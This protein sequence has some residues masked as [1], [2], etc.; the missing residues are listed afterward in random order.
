MTSVDNFALPYPDDVLTM[1]QPLAAL[2]WSM[3]LDSAGRDR[4]D[5]FVAAPRVTLVTCGVTTRICRGAD[6]SYSTD[7]PLLLLQ[8]I[9]QETEPCQY[10]P[11]FA[12]GAVGYFAYDLARRFVSL[13]EHAEDDLKLPEM[14]VGIYD[15]AVVVDHQ[16]R[17]CWLSGDREALQQWQNLTEQNCETGMFT[18]QG[19]VCSNLSAQ[20]YADRFARVQHYLQVG[21]CYQVNLAQRFCAPAKG[22]A[23]AL[24]ARLRRE[25]PAPFAAWLSFPFAQVLSAS[26][27]RFLRVQDSKVETKPIKGTRPRLAEPLADERQRADLQNSVKDRAENLMIVDLLRNDLGKSCVSGSVQVPRLFAQESFA[28]VHHLVSTVTGELAQDRDSMDLLRDCF[29]GGS[30]TGAPK[31]RSME[32]I[33]ELEPHRRGV[34]CGAIGYIGFDGNMD[35]NIAIR[36][37]VYTQGKVCFAAGGGITVDSSMTGEY[38]E[39]LDKAAALLHVLKLH[40]M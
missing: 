34:Y 14:A 10:K 39:S 6:C 32:I 33:E 20:D 31:L 22:D 5:I 18:V 25:N 3:W 19:E 1:F 36:S 26:P 38:Q 37:M 9:L 23:F 21:D 27:E 4:Y 8:Q 16:M 7:D 24:Y 40:S 2:P 15:W 30:I 17:S 11:P 12:G 13:P 29:P 35:T 28:S